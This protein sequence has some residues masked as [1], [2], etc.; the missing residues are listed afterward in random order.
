MESLNVTG[1]KGDKV[2]TNPAGT[3]EWSAPVKLTTASARNAAANEILYRGF[4]EYTV[5]KDMHNQCPGIQP[6]F[7]SASDRLAFAETA[8]KLGYSFGLCSYYGMGHFYKTHDFGWLTKLAGTDTSYDTGAKFDGITNYVDTEGWHVSGN[9]APEMGYMQIDATAGI[10]IG[11]P[12]LSSSLLSDEGTSCTLSFKAFAIHS[13]LRKDAEITVY[14]SVIR[15]GVKVRTVELKFPYRYAN[16]SP[17]ATD[18]I[19]DTEWVN[20]STDLE[21]KKGDAVLIQ[22]GVGYRWMI[23]DI[24]LIKK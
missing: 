13:S 9:T 12:A 5:Q 4:D 21:L 20:L 24:L 18:Y 16:A 6:S 14:V 1:P 10:G 2:M 17:T 23:D 3:S 8:D 7:S 19:P 11:T 22:N 15:G